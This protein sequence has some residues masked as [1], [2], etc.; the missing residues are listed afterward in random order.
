VSA[1]RAWA[2]AMELKLDDNPRA[3]FHYHSRLVKARKHS[4]QLE[5]VCAVRADARTRLEAEVGHTCM[6]AR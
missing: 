1:E 2:Y 6:R 4:Q 5:A 3:R